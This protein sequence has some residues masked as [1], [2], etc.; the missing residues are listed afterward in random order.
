MKNKFMLGM[1]LGVVAGSAVAMMVSPS[2]GKRKMKNNA[3]RAIK[4]LGDVVESVTAA[5]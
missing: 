4:A 5:L 2:P 1:G 3:G